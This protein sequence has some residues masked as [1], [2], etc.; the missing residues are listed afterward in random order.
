[1]SNWQALIRFIDD[2]VV[3]YFL[4][5]CACICLQLLAFSVLGP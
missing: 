5:H 2:L 4:V 3:A 1:M